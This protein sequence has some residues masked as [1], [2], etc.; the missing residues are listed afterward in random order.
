MRKTLIAALAVLAMTSGQ[1]LAQGYNITLKGNPDQADQARLKNGLGTFMLACEP[2]FR[3]YWGD[4]VKA[5]AYLGD[6]ALNYTGTTYGWNREM[7]I[8]VQVADSP[9]TIP[10]GMR[11]A[12]HKLMWV[13]G[14]GTKPGL[15]AKKDQAAEICGMKPSGNGSDVFQSFNGFQVLGAPHAT[16]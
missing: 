9:R 13:A 14:A 6:P 3:R 8:E 2:L 10:V 12:G 1:A 15:I 16:P 5:E 11:A 4:V 7:W